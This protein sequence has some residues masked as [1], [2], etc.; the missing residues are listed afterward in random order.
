MS[1]FLPFG[2]MLSNKMYIAD[3]FLLQF[4]DEA[5]RFSDIYHFGR[6][7]AGF[8]TPLT[9]E[10]LAKTIINPDCCKANTFT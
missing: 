6:E 4:Q 10:L 1:V 9:L 7:P 2:K 8:Q 5:N 3:N